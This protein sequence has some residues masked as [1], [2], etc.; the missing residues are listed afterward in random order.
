MP[1]IPDNSCSNFQLTI[2][3]TPWSLPDLTRLVLQDDSDSSRAAQQVQSL[4]SDSKLCDAFIVVSST[5]FPIHRAIVA[6]LSPF[7]SA[8]LCGDFLES[9]CGKLVLRDAA[10]EAVP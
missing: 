9:K 4:R 1:D 3:D 10:A 7:F 6:A 8:A 2:F 5:K